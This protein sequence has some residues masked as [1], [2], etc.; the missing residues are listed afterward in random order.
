MSVNLHVTLPQL[1][2]FSAKLTTGHLGKLEIKT[3]NSESHI[4]QSFA[5]FQGGMAGEGRG[6]G[7]GYMYLADMHTHAADYEAGAETEAG[8]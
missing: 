8:L 6:G 5:T 1:A 7:S 2:I 3:K 4:A